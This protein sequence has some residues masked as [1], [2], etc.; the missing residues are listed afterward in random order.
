[1]LATV[2][3][4]G[5][6]FIR[7]NM[8][9]ASSS[10]NENCD[11]NHSNL[12]SAKRSSDGDAN[13]FDLSVVLA[14]TMSLAPF[15]ILALD[16]KPDLDPQTSLPKPDYRTPSVLDFYLL[17]YQ[18]ARVSDES[19]THY[20]LYYATLCY[21]YYS[22]LLLVLS[23]IG[24]YQTSKKIKLLISGLSLLR[25]VQNCHICYQVRCFIKKKLTLFC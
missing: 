6:N 22:P 17:D 13:E 9:D 10:C 3:L 14:T 16:T 1:M 18:H 4:Q 2:L 8:P 24:G 15:N 21:K 20:F 7:H 5:L 19:K 25:D 11:R 23:P 12:T